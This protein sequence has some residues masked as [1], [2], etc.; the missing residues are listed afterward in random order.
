[1]VIFI[2]LTLLIELIGLTLF[3][4]FIIFILPVVFRFVFITKD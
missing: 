3:I 4:E 2:Q 1:L